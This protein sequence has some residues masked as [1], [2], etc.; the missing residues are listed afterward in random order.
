MRVR[1]DGLALW[2]TLVSAL[3]IVGAVAL[4]GIAGGCSRGATKLEP[5]GQSILAALG[6]HLVLGTRR[7]G[8]RPRRRG[9]QMF[10][11]L[12]YLAWFWALYRLFAND[13]RHASVRPIRPV[14]VGLDFRRDAP[15][16]PV[17]A[18]GHALRPC[19]RARRG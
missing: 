14:V 18:V 19:C 5:A 15:A 6:H 12:S 9:T 1:G 17:R 10:L 7:R 8:D 13:G 3:H 16:W 11:S 2:P 4:L